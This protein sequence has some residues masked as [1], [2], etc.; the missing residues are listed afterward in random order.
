MKVCGLRRVEDAELSLDLGATYLGCVMS[1]DSPRRASVQEVRDIAHV[2][3]G[4]A[5]VV[6]AFRGNSA[7]EILSTCAESGVRRVQI[8]GVAPQACQSLL[9][10]GLIIHPVYSVAMG[11]SCLPVPDSLPTVHRPALL[12]LGEGG[13]GG[14]AS[15]SVLDESCPAATFIAGGVTPDNLEHLL[16]RDP[17]GVDVSSGVESSPGVKDHARLRDLFAM[18]V[19]S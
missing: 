3:Q 10:Y 6:L 9:F 15:W 4:R 8:H 11:S 12:D 13:V 5:Q 17:F 16:D 14:P 2:A 18:T 7:A 19:A 1:K